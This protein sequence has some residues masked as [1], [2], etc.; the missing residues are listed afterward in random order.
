MVSEKNKRL[1]YIDWAKAISIALI[2]AGHILPVGCWEKTLAYAFHV[3]IFAIVGGILFSS[4]TCVSDFFKKL[5]GMF[6]KMVVPYVIWFAISA[7]LYYMSVE[8]MPDIVRW[9]AKMVDGVTTLDFS[10]FVKFF[11][12]YENATLWN[13]P[14]W[15]MP[16]YIFLSV[17]F[18]IF[19]SLTRGNRWAS[20]GLSL[21]AFIAVVV[22]DKLEFTINVG[23]VENVFGIKNY[24]MMLGFMGVGYALRPLLD[25]CANSFVDNRK[26]PFLYGSIIIFVITAWLCLKHN[27]KADYPGG[28]FPLSMYSASYNGCLPYILFA[29]LLSVSLL[30]A[31]MLLPS[32]K[33]A[34]LLSRNS[35]FIMMTHYFFF[36]FDMSFHF[37][38]KDKWTAAAGKLD[39][40]T[41]ELS[42]NIGYRDTVFIL[43]V[44]LII[45]FCVDCLK[46]ALSKT[47]ASR[48]SDN[49][50]TFIGFK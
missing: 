33:I 18:L 48:I 6:K 47:R 35:L 16:C 9:S 27:V 21:V 40:A 29:L 11:F 22:M 2:V 46:T 3:P 15:F 23:D 13:D 36:T 25:K 10:Q 19:V 39:M 45:F 12:F 43:V 37:L 17:F 38:T 1:D 20:C 7:S 8:K 32:S 42:R 49:L 4:P 34:N 50:F 44:Y 30:L 31:L 24:F 28:Y 14:L 5:W 26:N 41:W